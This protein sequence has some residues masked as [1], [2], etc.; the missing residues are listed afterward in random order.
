VF[1][2]IDRETKE[3]EDETVRA[4]HQERA[5]VQILNWKIPSSYRVSPIVKPN[6][7]FLLFACSHIP[8]FIY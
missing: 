8:F 3:F 7:F 1:I 6:E 2:V 5:T 4:K